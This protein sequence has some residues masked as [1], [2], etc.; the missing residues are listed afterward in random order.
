M[1]EKEMPERPSLEETHVVITKTDVLKA[2]GVF[3]RILVFMLAFAV[4]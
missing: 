3:A 2:S 4:P 1:Q